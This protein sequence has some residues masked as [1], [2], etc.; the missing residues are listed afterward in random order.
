MSEEKGLIRVKSGSKCS[1]GQMS[2]VQCVRCSSFVM[3]IGSVYTV[4]CVCV[5]AFLSFFLVVQEHVRQ[6][7]SPLF[8]FH[9][10]KTKRCIVSMFMFS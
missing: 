3:Q 9:S 8:P 5:R 7:S 2:A 1:T 4:R 10:H 6:L